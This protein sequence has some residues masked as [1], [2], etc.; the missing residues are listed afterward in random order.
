[1]CKM[2]GFFYSDGSSKKTN[3]KQRSAEEVEKALLTYL[4]PSFPF[5]STH[6]H[7]YRKYLQ[8]LIYFPWY[9]LCRF[10]AIS[11]VT[12][13][14]RSVCWLEFDIEQDKATYRAL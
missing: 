14:F 6:S 12:F 4:T 11:A 8:L 10:A 5:A 13:P 2:M 7:A 3:E 1:M 9:Y